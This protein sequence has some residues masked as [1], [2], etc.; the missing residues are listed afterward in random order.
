MHG[1]EANAELERRQV[2]SWAG[3]SRPQV[4]YSLEKLARLKLI[5]GAD[6]GMA[7]SGPDR[8][9]FAV[10]PHGRDALADAL[11]APHWT[12][13]RE[14][15]P[16]L[17]WMALSWQARPGVFRAQVERRRRFLEHELARDEATLRA[18]RREVG[19]RYH[20]AVWM[21]TLTLAHLRAEL[22]W[23]STVGREAG[24]RAPAKPR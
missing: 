6:T 2:R 11:E 23:L 10:T 22:R 13:Q 8:R 4:Y 24:R 16:F 19:H 15:P 1:Y 14:R 7:Q 20:E 3:I 9:E 21:L 17:T 12:M 5:R 18:V